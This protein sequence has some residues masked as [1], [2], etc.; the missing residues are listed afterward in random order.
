MIVSRLDFGLLLIGKIINMALGLVM[1]AAVFTNASNLGGYGR[2]EAFLFFATF[3]L[4]NAL[5]QAAFFRGFWFTEEWVKSGEFDHF[6][7]YP[8]SEIFLNAFKITDWIDLASLVPA[9]AILGYAFQINQ[10]ETA[11]ILPYL[12]ALT[13]GLGV[14]FAIELAIAA[15]NF[16]SPQAG[17]LHHIFRELGRSTRFPLTIYPEAWQRIFTFFI[18]VALLSFIPTQILLGELGLQWVFGA[19]AGAGILVIL[20]TRFWKRALRNYSS[21]SS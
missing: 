6:L 8:I 17:P 3:N 16:Y 11:G 2:Q 12:I 9:L 13:A 10:P 18:P 21:A 5:I 19:L 20:A 4:M 15:T 7:K 1:I 14:A